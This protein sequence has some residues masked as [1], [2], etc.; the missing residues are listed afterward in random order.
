M[1]LRVHDHGTPD[2]DFFEIEGYLSCKAGSTWL[3]SS[4]EIL[5]GP[6][7]NFFIE[8]HGQ[9]AKWIE[10]PVDTRLLLVGVP[11]RWIAPPARWTLTLAPV[12]AYQMTKCAA[13][14]GGRKGTHCLRGQKLLAASGLT[15][16]SFMSHMP[17]W[18]I[19][20]KPTKTHPELPRQNSRASRPFQSNSTRLTFE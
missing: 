3:K 16:T 10:A 12:K 14:R 13:R 15:H 5:S 18:V 11:V 20:L 4:K 19:Y 8:S 17:P 9:M 2:K 1:S 7:I 6:L